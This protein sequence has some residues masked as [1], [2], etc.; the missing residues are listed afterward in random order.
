MIYKS[1]ITFVLTGIALNAWCQDFNPYEKCII[2]KEFVCTSK[3]TDSKRIL[4]L[5]SIPPGEAVTDSII[6]SSLISGIFYHHP[7]AWDII[8]SLLFVVRMYN[9]NHG[10][11]YTDLN[12]YR[13]D[14]LNK[15]NISN[16]TD[17]HRYVSD[18]KRTKV[19][20]IS[21]LLS[22]SFRISYRND[23]LKG[24]VF[25]DF[26]C[27]EEA[28][29]LYI[30]INDS[31]VLEKWNYIRYP[32]ILGQPASEKMKS[33]HT[34]RA[35]WEKIDSFSIALDKPFHIL[36][37]NSQ[38]YLISGEGSIIA[39][40]NSQTFVSQQLPDKN[41]VLLVDKA[42]NELRFVSRETLLKQKG[43]SSDKDLI[44]LS[45]KV[46]DLN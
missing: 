34:M 23:T 36:H 46:L 13:L 40:D 29:Q 7:L 30:Y 10:M 26:Y 17:L 25:Y 39:L 44:K 41:G 16:R 45:V 18:T 43:K 37:G 21:P 32:L 14:Q 38:D 8:D 35:A 33:V 42:K 5:N 24:P 1:I 11:T 27:T 9:D 6:M 28:L 31:K 22:Y 2:G 4:Y 12:S 3:H 15:L 19:K 20:G